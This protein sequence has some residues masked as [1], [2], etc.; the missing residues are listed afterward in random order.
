MTLRKSAIENHY[1]SVK[2]VARKYVTAAYPE[3]WVWKVY[4]DG[5]SWAGFRTY[6]RALSYAIERV[7]DEHRDD[8][9]LTYALV[10]SRWIMFFINEDRKMFCVI[11]NQH[12]D[13]MQLDSRK[14]YRWMCRLKISHRF[15]R[16]L[17][18]IVI[19]NETLNNKLKEATR[20][21]WISYA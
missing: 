7:E 15:R 14:A 1:Y 3:P 13:Q 4:R 5:Y 12:T 16:E 9:L 6:E 11:D 8:W 17:T 18:G 19:F 21:E 2:R 10:D 20:G